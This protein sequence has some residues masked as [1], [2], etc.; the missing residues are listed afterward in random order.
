MSDRLIPAMF[1]VGDT[2]MA[3]PPGTPGSAQP[4]WQRA[5]VV[6]TFPSHNTYRIVF[7]SISPSYQPLY[8]RDNL[9]PLGWRDV[10]REMAQ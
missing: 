6:S 8:H 3:I 7:D 10:G 5:T 2:V 4:L 9:R 1:K